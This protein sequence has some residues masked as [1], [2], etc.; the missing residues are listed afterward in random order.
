MSTSKSKMIL[1]SIKQ[2]QFGILSPDEILSMSVTDEGINFPVTMENGHPKKG[3]LMD[4]RQGAIDNNSK[5]QTCF[6]NLA[7]CP[8]HFGHINL[9]KPV[10]HL[11]FIMKTMKIL[12]CVC[13]SCSK[14]LVCPNDPKIEKIIN[15]TKEQ[16]Q[17]RLSLIYKLCLKINICDNRDME[18]ESCCGS[19]QPNLKRS[20]FEIIAEW[21]ENEFLKK[22]I[23]LS[24]EKALTILKNITNEDLFILGMN[25]N[26]AR[27]EW[28]IITVLP[29]PPLSIRPNIKTVQDDLTK[30]LA[31]IVKVNNLIKNE[32]SELHLIE[33]NLPKL[34]FHV[35]TFIDN[36]LA[37]PFERLISLK[38]R[39]EGK[40]GRIRGNLLGKR[41][42]FSARSV[43]TPDPNLKIDY[44]GIP[45]SIAKKL[46][47][48]ELVTE[49]NIKK[50]QQLVT[51]GTTYPGANF[52]VTVKGNRIDL[53]S[54]NDVIIKCGYKVERHIRDNDLVICNYQPSIHKINM[55]GHR[56][57]I[58]PWSTFRMNVSS[59]KAYGANCDGDE[60][61]IHVPQSLT[62]KAEVENIHLIT[63]NKPI[64]DIVEDTLLGAYK[65]THRDVFIE[66]EEIMNLVMFLTNW[67]GKLPKPCILKPKPL[68]S[69]KQL[70]SLI[71][72]KNLNYQTENQTRFSLRDSTIL[73][74]NGELLMGILRK[75]TLSSC[76]GSL[77]HV[78]FLEFGHKVCGEFYENIQTVINNWLLLEGHSIDISDIILD[79][80]THLK[81]QKAIKKVKN[82][83][84][85]VLH[86][87]HDTEINRE[88]FKIKSNK[89][90]NDVNYITC[91][92]IDKYFI[93]KNNLM[94][95][96]KSGSNGNLRIISQIIGCIGQQ[97]VNGE[98]I[99]FGFLKRALP[100]FIK[101]DYGPEAQGFIENTYLSG[102]TPTE[103]FYH[104]M[105]GRDLLIDNVIKIEDT[106]R[107]QRKL[108][109]SMESL[110]VHYDGTVRNSMGQ[111]IQLNYGEDGLCGEV[112]EFQNLPTLKKEDFQFDLNENNLEGI[113]N[114]NI[115]DEIMTE[116]INEEL[117]KEWEQLNQDERILKKIFPIDKLNVLLPFNLK[118]MIWNAEKI[119][120][121]N[122]QKKTDLS[123]MKIIQGVRDLLKKCFIINGEDKLTKEG[124]E[125]ATLLFQFVVRSILCT[126][127]VTNHR[128]SSEAFEWLIN[129]IETRFQRAKISPGEMVGALAGQSLGEFATHMTYNTIHFSEAPSRNITLG[130][131]RFKEIINCIKKPKFPTMRIFLKEDSKQNMKKAETILSRLEHTTLKNIMKKSAI[132]YDPDPINSIIKDDQQFISVFNEIPDF[133]ITKLSPWLLRIELNKEKMNQRNL[134]M[135]QIAEKIKIEFGDDLNIMFN[136]DSSEHLIVRFQIMNN[137][138]KM[139]ESDKY[140]DDD[141]FLQKI[142][143]CLLN[144]VT[145]Q[146]YNGI[147]K[148]KLHKIEKNKKI[149]EYLILSEGSNLR[150]ILN[151]NDVDF[152]RTISSDIFE[153]YSILGIEAVR[154]SI[155]N[156]LNSIIHAYGRYVNNRHLALLSDVMTAEGHLT[157]INRIGFDR[158]DIGA[159]MRCSVEEK[160]DTLF[161]AASHGEIDPILGVSEKI[162]LGQLPRIGTGC[163]DLLI[164]D[165]K[166]R[167]RK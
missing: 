33:G 4:P 67:N 150:D 95:M 144:D 30:K 38:Q 44:I 164:D 126:K 68:W 145:L 65:M 143:L 45:I 120:H 89:I 108:V 12:R 90:L 129:E 57:K 15:D 141:V 85:E 51:N 98:R 115:I 107:I 156:E 70:F 71:I 133:D 76:A 154:K 48:P 49:F 14:L 87:A 92:I 9:A 82:N 62:T 64:M 117:K 88:T 26:Y 124:N 69:G 56:V 24:A 41:V 6:G 166:M 136:D 86:N 3:G 106:R 105:E 127:N 140:D 18:R 158:K 27:P 29:V 25:Y 74:E 114:E 96:M 81:I 118:R 153:I 54:K 103:F 149:K 110:M 135:Y 47:I 101:D 61:N 116:E 111:L 134:C 10:F 159:L 16:P 42:N 125:N 20:G 94:S 75:K 32:K 73:I 60:M 7:E 91:D 40:N 46:T 131:P 55:I 161:D 151:D 1:N 58:L 162:I 148:L 155:Q 112:L 132:Y 109:K 93:Q 59:I 8:G 97:N 99:P 43:I 128:L 79:A 31:N 19:Y 139:E 142:E 165:E 84:I 167:T 35:G 72:P 66:K 77:F 63:R 21:K 119:F 34:Q 28:M 163:V 113:F 5:C 80:N 22:R 50:L 37:Y 152:K 121:I 2:V 13:F 78:C 17:K 100:H 36:K 23:S 138:D 147:N 160:I 83:F 146:G 39:F 157:A 53:K 11:G 123:P 137:D 52:I 102:V 130:V 122:K 104:A